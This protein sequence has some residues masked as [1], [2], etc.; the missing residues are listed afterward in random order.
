MKI[1]SGFLREALKGYKAWNFGGD[2]RIRT[3]NARAEEGV[4]MKI[5]GGYIGF[6]KWGFAGTS[7]QYKA[8]SFGASIR[9]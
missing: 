9:S 6:A 7:E 5:S 4:H 2:N 8:W 1:S 3:S